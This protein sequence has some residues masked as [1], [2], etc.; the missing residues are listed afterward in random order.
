MYKRIFVALDGSECSGLAR[1]AAI[2]L[3][4]KGYGAQLIGCH[5]YAARLH[6]A[7][8]GDMEPGLSKSYAGEG[9]I[10]LR[11]THEGLIGTGM[12]FISDSYL[13]PLAKGALDKGITYESMTP[14]GR[15]YVQILRAAGEKSV[16]LLA[17][18]ALGQGRA[19]GLGSTAER[20]LMHSQSRDV[21]LMRRPWISEG[22]SILVGIDG[23]DNSYHAMRRAV[24]LASVFNAQIEAVSVYDPFFH[25]EVFKS[26]A[27]SLPGNA[28]ERF[29]LSAQERVH[30]EVIDEGLKRL[31]SD[32]LERGIGLA[33][34]AGIKIHSE[35][36]AGRVCTEIQNFVSREDISLIILG[37]WGLHREQES[38]I[39]SNALRLARSSTAS[40]LIVSPKEA[41]DQ[42]IKVSC[43]VSMTED[44]V[45]IGALAFDGTDRGKRPLE[46]EV[47]VMHKTRKF[48]PDF[49]RHMLRGKIQ[50]KIVQAG[51][52]IL[53]YEVDETIPAGPVQVTERTRLEVR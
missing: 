15:N 16:D 21:L 38:M 30:D 34:A 33:D 28:K 10:G 6:R 8:F 25:S 49:H 1:D 11:K 52:R 18:G 35:V 14:E 5:A 23:S 2:S 32:S 3:A 12:Q 39:G 47:V 48:A 24:E 51:D 26:I 41:Q 27:A 53:I 22:G 29:D 46:A 50:G 42:P 20:V 36:L 17:M 45:N 4:E 40:V 7:R 9:L 37:H 43:Q 19:E 44:N 13:E 31:Y